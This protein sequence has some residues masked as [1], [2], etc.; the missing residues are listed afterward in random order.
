VD[1]KTAEKALFDL[2]ADRDRK[3]QRV[4]A[5]DVDGTLTLYQGWK[6]YTHVGMLNTK[7]ADEVRA[8]HA[9]GSYIIIHT[10]RITALDG[11][12]IPEAVDALRSWLNLHQVPFHEIWMGTGKPYATEYWDDKAVRKP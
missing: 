5:V 3:Q 12:I 2:I 10:C 1:F 11:Q 7:V 9:A 6:G 8:E 4:V